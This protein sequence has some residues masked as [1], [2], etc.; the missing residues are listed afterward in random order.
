MCYSQ[1][2]PLLT[3]LFKDVSLFLWLILEQQSTFLC[4]C[5]CE[6]RQ[7]VTDDVCVQMHVHHTRD[8]CWYVSI[9]RWPCPSAGAL[10]KHSKPFLTIRHA[11]ADCRDHVNFSSSRLKAALNK[12]PCL[13]S[14]DWIVIHEGL[15]LTP[16]P[17]RA[18]TVLQWQEISKG[19]KKTSKFNKTCATFYWNF[20]KLVNYLCGKCEASA[21]HVRV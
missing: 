2:S 6:N 9:A 16:G 19:L 11:A 3:W 15:G 21:T 5:R 1:V 18:S 14:I 13:K 8:M 17:N 10:R 7:C 20:N 12:A 4:F